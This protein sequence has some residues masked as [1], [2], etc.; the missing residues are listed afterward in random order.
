MPVRGCESHSRV[1]QMFEQLSEPLSHVDFPR[2]D[3]LADA[4]ESVCTAVEIAREA[5][6][7]RRPVEEMFPSLLGVD[8]LV[9]KE[10]PQHSPEGRLLRRLSTQWLK[11]IEAIDP[12][13][14]RT[15]LQIRLAP[16]LLPN[17]VEE[18]QIGERTKRRFVRL[19]VAIINKGPGPALDVYVRIEGGDQIA[20][21]GPDGVNLGR[22]DPDEIQV[23]TFRFW[24]KHGEEGISVVVR[25]T[26][27]DLT[28]A[29]RSETES[30]T[31]TWPPFAKDIQGPIHN[32]YVIGRPVGS[33]AEFDT[34]FRN[35]ED[36]LDQLC[37][38]VG[39]SKEQGVIVFVR[40]LRCTGKTSLILQFREQIRERG[41]LLV[42]MDCL[43]LKQQ[44]ALA[45]EPWSQER[46]LREVAGVV[47]ATADVG[48]PADLDVAERGE[49]REFLESV[50]EETGCR[51]V[52]VFDEADVLSTETFGG[53]ARP[54]LKFLEDLTLAGLSFVFVH[55]LVRING[56]WDS[57][58]ISH[59]P[60]RVNLLERAET[61]ALATEVMPDLMYT[62]LA[63]TYLW[64]ITGGYPFLTQL[65]CHHLV[66]RLNG[67]RDPETGRLNGVIEIGD[68]KRVVDQVILSED[69]RPLI[70]YLRWSF[71]F[72]E[73]QLL[74]QL[75]GVDGDVDVQTGLIRPVKVV[76]GQGR[77]RERDECRSEEQYKRFHEQYETEQT[78]RAF[79]RL[80][81]KEVLDRHGDRGSDQNRGSANLYLRVGF[82]WL[83][84]HRLQRPEKSEE[85]A[86]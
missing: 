41:F 84:L 40:G 44:I 6:Q 9:R 13:N 23:R 55:E 36:Q 75:A 73:R 22:L 21:D 10:L 2:P 49:F 81:T 39:R 7:L 70:D 42:Y 76:E 65:V 79:Q 25:V 17:E 28:R 61:E 27:G 48:L 71:G 53:F 4:A 20:L 74:L 86:R 16:S 77:V 38:A 12:L 56:F 35:R 8:D 34:V 14:S 59:E 60:V 80:L 3:E 78:K 69:D 15:C 19:P 57:I 64:R 72:G 50:Q 33:K 31:Y 63:L 5:F 18:E 68:V 37:W 82:L 58:D 62:P 47:A 46:F 43:L 54:I 11:R 51:L 45:T 67:R 52:L 66:K 29:D 24:Q 32:P 26:Y 1:Y 83:Y 85:T 30:P